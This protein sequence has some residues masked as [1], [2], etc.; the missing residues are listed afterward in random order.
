MQLGSELCVCAC[1]CTCTAATDGSLVDRTARGRQKG[2]MGGNKEKGG[3]SL[4]HISS[5]PFLLPPFP[6]L[7]PVFTKSSQDEMET[8]AA[9]D[10]V[11]PSS[12][13]AYEMCVT[14]L[15]HQ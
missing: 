11:V 12:E 10:V 15:F 7:L 13:L 4:L 14:F 6:R 3:S 9:S 8:S 5:H 2:M 1:A